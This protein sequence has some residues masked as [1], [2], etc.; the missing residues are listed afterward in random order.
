M[1][2]ERYARAHFA[3][4]QDFEKDYHIQVP[5]NFN[6]SFDC[7]DE[8]A[9]AQP[10]KVALVWCNDK[11]EQRRYTFSQMA[12]QADAAA[13]YFA[14]NGIG[15]GDKVLLLL[16]RRV[17]FWFCLLGLAKLGAV[18]I[19]AT[20]Q[21]TAKDIAYR[22]NAASVAAIVAVED[23]GVLAAVE[24]AMA[25]SPTVRL[26]VKLGAARPGWQLLDEGMAAQAEGPALPRVTENDDLMLLYFTSGTT[27]MPK[28]VAH[29]FTY[30]LGHITTARYWHNLHPGSLHLT[31]ADTGWAKAAW[32]KIYGQWLCEA[33]VFVYDHD[34]FNAAELLEVV[35]RHRVTSFCA[36]PTVFRFLI[37]EDL[38]QYDLSALEYV[39]TA[40]EPLNAEV[41]QQFKNQTGLTIRESFGQTET[42][43]LVITTPYMEARPGSLGL[44]SPAYDLV[45]LNEE[46]NEVTA[47]VEG[48]I[49]V[50]LAPGQV[51]G[52]F[53][54]Y[55]LDD[56]LTRSVWHDGFYHTGDKARQDEQGYLWFIG[57]VDD[58]IK[59]SGYRIGPFEVESA[60]M[61]HPAVLECAVTGAP[62]PVRGQVVK[63]TIVLAK[64]HEP[65]E[66]L[67]A[68]LQTHVKNTTAPYKYPRVVEFAEALPKTISGKIQ[69]V[70]IRQKTLQ[71]HAQ[72]GRMKVSAERHAVG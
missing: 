55:Y 69:R 37:K 35:S 68:E 12:R 22:N 4:Q 39:T 34:K 71:A 20:H 23:E 58:M 18:A 25:A 16:K 14:T 59:S 36:P 30:P 67:V 57:R 24:T 48:E 56:E 63:A 6:F 32:G 13:R 26:L 27:G 44:P 40:G 17:Q 19:P 15:K 65:C 43:P 66:E 38:T 45:L 11:G 72:T 53:N 60:L 7:V 70:V 49:C 9:A 64:G 47:G 42:T 52:V 50:R 46:C 51:P 41:F 54:G 2:M 33:A 5:Q 28:M 61:E 3:S 21:L 8:L 31:V 62:D 29:N 1:L 10:D